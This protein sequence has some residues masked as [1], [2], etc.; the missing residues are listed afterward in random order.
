M[1]TTAFP[2]TIVPFPGY[3]CMCGLVFQPAE[4]QAGIGAAETEAVRHGAGD[5]AFDAAHKNRQAGA[6]WVGLADVGA[7]GYEATIEH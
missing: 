4:N 5:G 7:S 2:L 3:G 6:G 1:T